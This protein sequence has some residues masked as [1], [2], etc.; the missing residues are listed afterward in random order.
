M[1][2]PLS[3]VEAFLA[4]QRQVCQVAL[5]VYRYQPQSLTEVRAQY[6][7]PPD[8]L[9][10]QYERLL[11]QLGDDK[12]IAFDSLVRVAADGEPL[13]RHIPLVDFK[14]SDGDEVQAVVER[15]R[16]ENGGA[17]A[18]LY[19]SGRA[20]HLYLGV[21][22]PREEWLRFMGRT[23]LLNL[24]G[25][26]EMID[27]RWVGHRLMGGYAALRWSARSSRSNSSPELVRKW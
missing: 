13:E 26:P 5:S 19:S 21:L 24:P 4:A 11:T 6:L 2:H 17:S 22:L 7:I 23:L 8:E 1:S 20:F 3:F 14:S 18:A 27:A 12:E 25:Q 10:L 16:A 9:R 15:L